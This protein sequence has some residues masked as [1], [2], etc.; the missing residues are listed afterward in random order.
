V[1]GESAVTSVAPLASSAASSAIAQLL[2]PLAPDV[3]FRDYWERRYCVVS[4]EDPA[5]YQTVLT[6]HDLDALLHQYRQSAGA[7][8]IGG[9]V[10]LVKS[11]EHN[12]LRQPTPT[13]DLGL[14]DINGL[15]DAYRRGF[16]VIVDMAQTRWP[17]IAALCQDLEARL[18]F[19]VQANVYVTPRGAQGFAPHFDTHDVF[20]LQIAGSKM[21]RMYEGGET[22]PMADSD[23]HLSRES[24]RA[25]SAEFVL[26]QGDLL[27]IPRG[28]VHEAATTDDSSVH[29]TLGMHVWRWADLL[30]ECVL[31]LAER[32]V[33]LRQSLP[34]GLFA[35]AGTE[36]DPLDAQLRELLHAC[37]ESADARQAL[38]RMGRRLVGRR[39][40][41]PD[42]HFES[43]DRLD[44]IAPETRL[45]RRT[46]MLC[47]VEVQHDKVTIAF[48]G[49]TMTGPVVL[50]TALRFIAGADVFQVRDLPGPEWAPL[51]ANAQVVLAKRLV[52][53]GLLAVV[54][55]SAGE[56]RGD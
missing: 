23:G 43:L 16:T 13:T 42:G 4:R 56:P 30:R 48:P 38:R 54:D 53:A 1:P 9:R 26:R 29:I 27:Y 31:S 10:T 46:G 5:H 8:A 12:A 14:L 20:V 34:V 41:V 40:P 45:R 15:Y 17:A 35:D 25:P 55:P 6:R 52:R 24:L 37:A 50:E 18:H 2:A 7:S 3:F 11:S 28:V 51:S 36:T 47:G 19:G 44:A 33:R 39:E 32:D 49:G 21:W 22:L